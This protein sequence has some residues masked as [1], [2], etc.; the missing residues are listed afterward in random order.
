MAKCKYL[1]VKQMHIPEVLI[2]CF[3]QGANMYA[4]FLVTAELYKLM[5]KDRCDTGAGRQ[6]I[7][8]NSYILERFL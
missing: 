3:F 4:E 7:P 6:A 2:S 8:I 5:A 1:A